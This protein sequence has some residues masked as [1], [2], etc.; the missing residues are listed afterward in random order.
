MEYV[1]LP[2][3]GVVN[4]K[5]NQVVAHTLVDRDVYDQIISEGWAV[6]QDNKG[7]VRITR[8]ANGERQSYRLHRYILDAKPDQIVDHIS[9]DVKDNRRSNLRFATRS[10]NQANQT[11]R[12]TNKSGYKGVSWS[13]AMGKWQAVIQHNG[14]S[15]YLGC[16]EDPAEAAKA[17]DAAAIE[18]KGVYARPNT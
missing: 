18:L 9:M 10:E 8:Y 14:K 11:K 5:R 7:Y 1:N 15:K 6:N 17:Y 16:Y 13:K 3:R 2:I 4:G 12:S